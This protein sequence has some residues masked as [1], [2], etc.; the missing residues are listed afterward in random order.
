MSGVACGF[1]VWGLGV[2]NKTGLFK[3]AVIIWLGLFPARHQI[4]ERWSWVLLSFCHS[5]SCPG[6]FR[7]SGPIFSLATL[8]T[9]NSLSVRSFIQEWEMCTVQRHSYAFPLQNK[10]S[11][12]D[13][14]FHKK[15]SMQWVYSG[16]LFVVKYLSLIDVRNEISTFLLRRHLLEISALTMQE[17]YHCEAVTSNPPT[18]CYRV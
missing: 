8:T 5:V 17:W 9:A 7:E 3:G 10:L 6:L 16:A 15:W 2:E 18:S 4:L 13:R 1:Q 14:S 11:T 12:E